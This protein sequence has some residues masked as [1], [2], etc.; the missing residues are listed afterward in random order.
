MKEIKFEGK[1]DN[2]KD[3]ILTQL[4]EMMN[5]ADNLLGIFTN[6]QSAI[7]ANLYNLKQMAEFAKDSIE[8]YFDLSSE[9]RESLDENVLQSKIDKFNKAMSTLIPALRQNLNMVASQK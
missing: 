7:Q 3:Q 5:D 8:S 9:Q 6:Q 2:Q 4:T 1:I